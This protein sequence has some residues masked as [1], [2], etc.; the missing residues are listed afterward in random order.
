MVHEPF[1]TAIVVAMP[2]AQDETVDPP[3]IEIEQ[4][5]IADQY[6]GRIAEVQQVPGFATGLGQLEV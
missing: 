6:L 4:I 1:D 5:K 3:W 2:V